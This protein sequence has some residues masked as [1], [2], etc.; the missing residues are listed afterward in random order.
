MATPRYKH[1]FFDLDRTLWDFDRNANE[2][3]IDLHNKYDLQGKGVS[4]FN[5]FMSRYHKINLT[6][7]DHYRKGQIE[8]EV[9]NVKRFSLTLD[10]YGIDDTSL[11]ENIAKDYIEI[12]PTKNHLFP[13]THQ[14]LEYLAD[15]YTLHIITNGFEEVQHKKLYNAKL[16][17]FFSSIITSE[18]AG[19][20]KPDVNI[21]RYAF[22]ITGANAN[23]SLMVGDDIEVDIIGAKEAGMDQVL[24]DYLKVLPK[25]ESTYY[26][27]TMAELMMIL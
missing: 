17:R 1:I 8:K 26:V 20:K 27:N 22:S 12:S 25:D 11:S 21:F 7:W 18:D 3:F 6:L 16:S 24:V 10:S 2:T 15:K 4:D 19:Y 9:L 14:V 23:E 13:D 5:D